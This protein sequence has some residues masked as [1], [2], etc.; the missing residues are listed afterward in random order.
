MCLISSISSLQAVPGSQPASYTFG[1]RYSFSGRINLTTSQSP[2]SSLPSSSSFQIE[3]TWHCCVKIRKGIY[4][5]ERRKE[6]DLYPTNSDKRA[7]GDIQLLL[8]TCVLKEHLHFLSATEL[9]HT[10]F[11]D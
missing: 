1:T 10:L 7:S 6:V 4:A 8:T 9:A 3:N 11:I 5:V 2:A